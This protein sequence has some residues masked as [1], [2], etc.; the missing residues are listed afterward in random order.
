[1]KGTPIRRAG[2]EG[3]VLG[4]NTESAI[5]R[6]NFV[7]RSGESGILISEPSTI[8][9]GNTSNRNGEWGIDSASAA[10]SGNKARGNGQAQQCNPASLCD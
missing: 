7:D 8:V 10:G 5:I 2:N 4:N 1:M 3:I 9:N 6:A